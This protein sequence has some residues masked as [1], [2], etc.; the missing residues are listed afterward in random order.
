MNLIDEINAEIADGAEQ[1][2]ATWFELRLGKFTASE[3]HKLMGMGKRKMTD[4]ELAN[5]P[6]GP[7]GGLL[8][9]ST[10]V[11]DD[12]VLSAGAI[13]YI[14]QK[15]AELWTGQQGG[16][17]SSL[18]TSWGE[19]NEGYAREAFEN[20]KGVKISLN[21]HS[22]WEEQPEE[23][24]GSSD[25]FVDGEDAII[26]IKNPF[27]SANHVKY[28]RMKS[29]TDLPDEYFYQCHANMLFTGKSKCY[30]I[31]YDIRVKNEKNRLFVMEIAADTAVQER[32]KNKLRV[33]IKEKQRLLSD[34]A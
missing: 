23:A 6:I 11:E 21:G 14:E 31:S 13:T 22:V 19:E 3:I 27:N 7:R 12:N 18:A 10:T 28:C 1:R 2:S 34:L 5:R 9:K 16:E 20:L 15:I 8:D 17:F 24:G 26:E 4:K 25:G 29:P 33:A 30:F 32:I